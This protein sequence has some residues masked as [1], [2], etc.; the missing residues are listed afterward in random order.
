MIV[1]FNG[2]FLPKDRVRI[3]PD[4]RGFLFGDGVY[5][6]I[7]ADRGRLFAAEPHF[8]RLA[9]S[10]R[11]LRIAQPDLAQIQAAI[12]GVLERND[13]LDCKAAVYI[14]ITRGAAPR[15]H[16]FPA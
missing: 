8:R 1:Y 5:E 2:E 7:R 9:R 11:E 12:E 15:R 6:A 4:D 14:Q 16:A 10:L 13:L 3:S